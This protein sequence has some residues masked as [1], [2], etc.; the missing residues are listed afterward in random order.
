MAPGLWDEEINYFLN[1]NNVYMDNDANR[2]TILADDH[3]GSLPDPHPATPPHS[4]VEGLTKEFDIVD[5][6]F[7]QKLNHNKRRPHRRAKRRE[8]LKSKRTPDQ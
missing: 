4:Q 1:L 5:N 2:F 6:Y 3:E 7:T 8:K